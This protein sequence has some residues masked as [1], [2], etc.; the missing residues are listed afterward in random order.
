MVVDMVAGDLAIFHKIDNCVSAEEGC[1][2]G[3]VLW[4]PLSYTNLSVIQIDS[5]VRSE[6]GKQVFCLCEVAIT[7]MA[8]FPSKGLRFALGS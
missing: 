5:H 7:V 6:M 1:F 2:Y 3:Y 8:S 4:E